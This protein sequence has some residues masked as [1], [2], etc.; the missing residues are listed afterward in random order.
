MDG[1]D[2]HVPTTTTCEMSDK[3]RLFF[4]YTYI[5]VEVNDNEQYR[6]RID[7]GH[8]LYSNNQNDNDT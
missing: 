6:V 7:R 5:C 8:S 1:R 3:V 4:V 2:A